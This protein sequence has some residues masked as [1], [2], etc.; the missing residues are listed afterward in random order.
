M[1][2]LAIIPARGGSKGVPRKNLLTL[3]GKPLV[4]WSIE[5]ASAAR[6]VDRIVVSTDD[7]E[8]AAV[9]RRF[10]AE[11]VMRPAELSDDAASSELALLHA[12]DE[13]E[14]REGEDLDLLVFLQCT[15][16]LTAPE[17]IDGTI[18]AL[19]AQ[20]ADSCFTVTDFHAFVWRESAA[21]DAIAL[22]HNARRRER[23]QDRKPEFVETGSV[24]AMRVDGF[25]KA[26]HR[27]FGRTAMFTVPA[28]RCL[29]IDDPCDLD[30]AEMRLRRRQ[31]RNRAASLP[32]PVGALVLDFDGVMTDNRV[33]VLEDGR[34]A[35]TCSRGD[36][37]GLALLRRLG[38]PVLV[39]S[40]EPNPVVRARCRKLEIECLHGIDDKLPALEAWLRQRGLTLADAVFVGN[41]V[42]DVECLRAAGCGI[43]VGD[44]L[45]EARVAADLV[46]DAPGGR[47]AVREVTDWIREKLEATGDV[48]HD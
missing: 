1:T 22:N 41:D 9:S 43:A 27:F 24:Y 21:G 11:V 40:K 25:R 42:N 28:E 44:A 6:R 48:T 31:R 39:L 13:L 8:I 38:L 26:Q 12:L 30:V 29:E 47:G 17:D 46:L 32:D 18:A 36:G 15:S 20:A 19:E 35:V 4:A 34:E 45:P 37:Q 2:T 33:I 3:C 23:R 10:G 14:R 7:A 16:P 5:A